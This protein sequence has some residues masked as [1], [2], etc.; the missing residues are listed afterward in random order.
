MNSRE[1]V[2]KTFAMEKAD[3]MPIDYFGNA[4]INQKLFRYFHTDY[5]GVLDAL[6]VDFRQVSVPYTGKKLFEERPNMI[7]D[8][9]YGYYARWIE[10]Q[11]GG[12]WDYSYFPLLGANDDAIA[13]YPVPNADD[14]DYDYV[15]RILD[16]N[17]TR[18]LFVGNGGY[19]DVINATGR[20][21]GMEQT[22]IN[23][24]TEDEATLTYIRRRSAMELQQLERMIERAKGRIDFMW[25]GE[26][27]GTQIA[28]MISM[29]LY[30]NV[31]RP[32]HSQYI[33]LAKSHGL[34]VMIHSCGSSS[35]VYEE[36]IRMGVRAVDTL[37]PEAKDMQ[38][39]YLVEHFGGR[40]CF[41][42]SISTAG[43]LAYGTP[44]DVEDNVRE[45][46]D[47]YRDTYSYMISPTHSIQDNSPLENVL[48]LYESAQKYGKY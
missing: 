2:L 7:V 19:A 26:D 47:I 21:M 20:V 11:T 5:E 44:K 16:R 4:G 27:L 32:I 37:Q 14:F 12:Y 30:N 8:P 43:P 9:V 22:L 1:R 35:W 45:T 17:P 13:N 39:Q 3:R 10:H 25:I 24:A 48:A 42:G 18:A 46:C 34:P 33:E 41:H 31:L 29:E 38:P 28:P 23:L 40:L 15:L 36:W 6:D